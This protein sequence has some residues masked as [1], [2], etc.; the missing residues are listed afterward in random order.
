MDYSQKI[1]EN[2]RVILNSLECPRRR[3]V[4]IGTALCW[5]ACAGNLAEIECLLQHGAKLQTNDYRAFFLAAD[6]GYLPAVELLLQH[7][8]DLHSES[9]QALRCA[10]LHGHLETVEY[11]LKLGANLHAMDDESLRKA[12]EN[13][14]LSVVECL[15]ERGADIH[16][17]DDYALRWAAKGGHLAVVQ[18]LLRHG[19]N[20][21]AK[22]D[23]ALLWAVENRHLSVVEHLLERGADPQ[24]ISKRTFRRLLNRRNENL[25]KLLLLYDLQLERETPFFI[26]LLLKI[27]FD[28]ESLNFVKKNKLF[29]LYKRDIF[30][31]VVR[32]LFHLYYR[33]GSPAYYR[34]V[35]Y[36]I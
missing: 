18:S 30:T 27:K 21:H 24:L 31:K 19:A 35:K 17:V 6:T 32:L 3:E 4:F 5:A 13:G 12:A 25:I 23:E 22:K 7:G 14:H 10:A 16:A 33:P 29:A 20:I 2:T 11:L 15:L 28:R 8:A 26:S 36:P 34:A 9:D 1:I